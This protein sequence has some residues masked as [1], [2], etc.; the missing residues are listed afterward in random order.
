V[1]A[2]AKLLGGLGS[3]LA[4]VTA[5]VVLSTPVTRGTATI[6]TVTRPRTGRVPSRQWTGRVVVQP[7]RAACAEMMFR[8][9]LA[10]N[11]T[12]ACRAASGPWLVTVI[13]NVWRCPTRGSLSWIRRSLTGCA[14]GR[15][16]R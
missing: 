6:R 15:A 14:P 5:A 3:R 13:V 10:V 7:W 11:V 4:L 12:T 9:R 16:G 2:V 8:G 1:M